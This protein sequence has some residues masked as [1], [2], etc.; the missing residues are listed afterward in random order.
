MKIENLNKLCHKNSP[1]DRI[2]EAIIGG[3]L[4][5]LSIFYELVQ[6]HSHLSCFVSPDHHSGAL[7]HMYRRLI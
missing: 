2:E 6:I 5:I 7:H 4:F 3:L 1:Y